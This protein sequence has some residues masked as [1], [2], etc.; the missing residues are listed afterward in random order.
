[1]KI[2]ILALHL[3]FGG[4]EKAISNMANIFADRYEVEIICMYDMPNAPAYPLDKRVKVTYLLK[5]IPNREAFRMSIKKKQPIRIMKEGIRAVSILY[6]KK[7]SLKRVIQSIQDGILITT[8]HEDSLLL[9]AYGN[10]NVF[11]IAQLHHDHKNDEK[12]LKQFEENYKNIDVFVLLT[13]Q[14]Q[15]EVEAHLKTNSM[16]CCTIPNFIDSIPQP[17]S[18]NRKEKCFVACGRLHEVKG[19]ERLLEAMRLLHKKCPDWKLRLIGDGEGRDK[20]IAYINKH[21][22]E[23]YVELCGQKTSKEI[24]KI[25]QLSSIYLMTSYSE[26][27]PYVLIEAQSCCLPIVAFDV[28][29]GPRAVV[30]DTVSGYLVK[31]GDMDA[32]VKAASTL[33]NDQFLREQMADAAYKQSYRFSKE[34]VTKLWFELLTEAESRCEE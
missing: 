17:C 8:R 13:E 19:F 22:M 1:M 33:A 27:L 3:A 21:H 16:R 2:R 34:I 18:L 14:L 4:V 5:A 26:G 30:E 11:K 7:A 12:M 20:L 6:Q 23:A 9:N 31:D 24:E 32:F 25:N 29:V 10:P 15:R 28:R